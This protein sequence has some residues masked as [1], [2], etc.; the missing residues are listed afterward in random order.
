MRE[1]SGDGGNDKGRVWRRGVWGVKGKTQLT[2]IPSRQGQGVAVG[3][4]GCQKAKH[5]SL[6]I[7]PHP[8]GCTWRQPPTRTK[9]QRKDWVANANVYI[10]RIDSPV[11]SRTAQY[12]HRQ[13]RA[14]SAV[15]SPMSS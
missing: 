14:I 10:K 8:S 2:G 7:L 9:R 13:S 4:L 6:V 11:H 12:R 3:Y 5:S 1:R 15:S